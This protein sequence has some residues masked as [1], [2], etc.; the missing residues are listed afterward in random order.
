MVTN[1]RDPACPPGL[2]APVGCLPGGYDAAGPQVIDADVRVNNVPTQLL[3][4]VKVLRFNAAV[5]FAAGKALQIGDVAVLVQT[6]ATVLL[7]KEPAA[8]WESCNGNCDP[9]VVIPTSRFDGMEPRGFTFAPNGEFLITTKQN[10]ILRFGP[11][12]QRVTD[13]GVP[14]DFAFLPGSGAKI[15]VGLQGDVSRAFVAI[16]NNGIIQRYRFASDVAGTPDGTGIPDG[17]VSIDVSA[18]EGVTIATGT[19]DAPVFAGPN[20]VTAHSGLT[21][22]WDKITKDG[23][24]IALCNAFDDPREGDE[25]E[26]FLCVNP[27]TD[28]DLD[29][30]C[31]N[32]TTADEFLNLGLARIVP[33]YFSTF[34]RLAPDGSTTGPF[35]AVICVMSVNAVFEDGITDVSFEDVWL[36][37]QPPCSHDPILVHHGARQ[38]SDGTVLPRGAALLRLHDGSDSTRR[39]T[40]RRS[41]GMPATFDRRTEE[42]NRDVANAGNCTTADGVIPCKLKKLQEVLSETSSPCI[43]WRARKRLQN[44]LDRV[45]NSFRRSSD[46]RARAALVSFQNEITNQSEAFSKCPSTVSADLDARAETA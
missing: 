42:G 44:R 13:A 8:G 29:P 18:P 12:G 20:I 5:D 4:D 41:L 7:Y 27:D 23:I 30:N 38:A 16:H 33:S 43:D 19:G 45:I 40:S 15:A 22:T 25:E 1:P 39:R 3:A 10:L 17:E 36:G 26:L 34:Q 32:P 46:C 35:T 6:P 9:D 31:A 37:Y 24:T 21:T 28:P 14:L 11:D 2:D